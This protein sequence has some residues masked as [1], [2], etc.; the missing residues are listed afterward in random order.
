V[1]FRRTWARL[2]VPAALMLGLALA[3]CS[4]KGTIAPNLEPETTL[5]V[6]GT[7]DTVNHT[8]RLYWFGSDTDG[9]VVGYQLRM[10]HPLLPADTAWSFTTRTDSLFVVYTPLGTASPTLEVRAVDDD[11]AIDPTPARQGF[12]FSNE[13]PSVDLVLGPGP[14]DTTFASVTVTWQP[15]DPDGDVSGMEYRVWMDGA[16]DLAVTTTATTYTVPSDLFRVGG[17]Y[18]SGYRTLYVQAVDDGGR[19]GSPDS[20]RWFVRAPVT[21]AEARLLIIDDVPTTN[22]ANVGIDTMFTNTAARNLPAGTWSILRL[23]TTQPFRSSKDV[24]QTFKLFDAVLWYRGTQT[25]F[26]VLMRDYRD[27]MAAYLDAGGTLFLEG[28]DLIEGLGVS[29]PLDQAF[30]QTYL[31]SDRLHRNFSTA[32]NDS[33]E[34]WGNRV[35]TLLRSSVFADSLRFTNLIP[36][37]GMRGFVVRDSAYVALWARDSSLAPPNDNIEIPVAVSVPQP[38]GGRAVVVTLPLRA[39]NGYFSVPRLLAKLFAQLGLTGP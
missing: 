35:G 27:G 20:T 29:G 34:G 6:Q 26:P 37:Q 15:S 36:T 13:P 38:S 3:A 11:G 22:P 12:T 33:S 16:E 10:L 31:G 24:E 4:P 2:A 23:Q 5:F 30:V 17:A 28:L 14:N 18:V 9:D 1:S 32:L 8:V 7:L 25:N 21:G 39:A 19:V